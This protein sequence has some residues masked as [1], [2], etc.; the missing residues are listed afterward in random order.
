VIWAGWTFRKTKPFSFPVAGIAAVTIL[1]GYLLLN[2]V[3]PR[4]LGIPAGSAFG[5]FAWEIYGQIHGGTGWHQAIDDLGTTNSAIVYRAAFQYFTEHPFSLLIG[6]AKSYRDFFLPD[7]NSVFVFTFTHPGDWPNLLLWAPTI[8]LLGWGFVRVLKNIRFSPAGL[9]VAGFIG[10]LASIPF[11]PPIDGGGRFYAGTIPFLFIL[12]AVAVG[13]LQAW[14]HQN[15]GLDNLLSGATFLPRYGSVLL[16]GLMVIVPISAYYLNKPPGLDAPVCPGKQNAFA[17]RVNPGSYI[18]L[19]SGRTHACGLIPDICLSEFKKNGTEN[20][21]DDFYQE[22]LSL[23]QPSRSVTR[24]IPTINLVD[25][26][27]HYFVVADPPSLT[28]DGQ[29]V[30]G[31]ASEIR[32][33][34]QSIYQIESLVPRTK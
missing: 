10:I 3:Y 24:I 17:I 18:D 27:F 31:C 11:L 15:M 19:L 25:S 28:A 8:F 32:T 21:I 5:N 2:T 4:L 30:S 12:P 13:R 1:V 6:A 22:L 7:L 34:N 29:V 16:L 26:S 20:N 9:T 14:L 23:A 33:R